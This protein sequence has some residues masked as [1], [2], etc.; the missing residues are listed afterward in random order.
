[1]R[2]RRSRSSSVEIAAV[3]AQYGRSGLSQRAFA[4]QRGL[5][6]STLCRW[7]RQNRSKTAA[8]TFLRVDAPAPPAA[9]FELVLADGR[10]LLV[11]PVFDPAALRALLE[12]LAAC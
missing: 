4:A 2:Q 6:L 7:L 8:T 3:I 12:V 10:R 11:P 9:D 5:P 1:M